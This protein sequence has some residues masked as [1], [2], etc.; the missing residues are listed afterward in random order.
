M[1]PVWGILKSGDVEIK[2]S[3][4]LTGSP[5][6]ER[7]KFYVDISLSREFFL[8]PPSAHPLTAAEM[9]LKE[10]KSLLELAIV[11]NLP[12]FSEYVSS[13]CKY[14]H[15]NGDNVEYCLRHQTVLDVPI[16]N[17]SNWDYVYNFE[18]Y[19]TSKGNYI[20]KLNF[21][22]GQGWKLNGA[23]IVDKWNEK[24]AGAIRVIRPSGKIF[25]YRLHHEPSSAAYILHQTAEFLG[26]IIDC[27][28]DSDSHDFCKYWFIYPKVY[29]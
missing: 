19:H 27:I 25:T 2:T 18:L 15:I 17:E 4:S 16:G 1:E 10:L 8:I 21:E 6:P 7:R 28:N 23:L 13:F 11:K 9:A 22:I 3:G 26:N 14:C 24:A 20:V 29:A 12:P 5:Y